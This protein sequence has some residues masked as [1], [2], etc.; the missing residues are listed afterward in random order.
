[1]AKRRPDPAK[2]QHW[3]GLIQQ[4]QQSG[5]SVRVFCAQHNLAVPSFYAWR[6]TL[7]QRDLHADVTDAAA[8][9]SPAAAGDP[10]ASLPL[11]VPLRLAHGSAPALEVILPDGLLVRVPAGFDSDTLRRLLALVRE[12]SC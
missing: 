8:S 9:P 11:F 6:R 10:A 4:Q 5:L 3:R 7:T 2:E 12:A 1:M